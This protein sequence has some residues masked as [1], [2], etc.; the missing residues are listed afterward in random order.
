MSATIQLTGI[1]SGNLDVLVQWEGGQT[2]QGRT[3]RD[4]T[5]TFERPEAS[6]ESGLAQIFVEGT[7]IYQGQV[8]DFLNIPLKL[9]DRG[10]YYYDS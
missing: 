8:G 2:S 10:Y 6:P 5:L 3:N 4:G 7:P 9:Y 1:G